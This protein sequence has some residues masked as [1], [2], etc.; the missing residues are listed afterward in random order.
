MLDQIGV[1][2]R[3]EAEKKARPA[4]AGERRGLSPLLAPEALFR[5]WGVCCRKKGV[6]YQGSWGPLGIP[7]AQGQAN[8]EPISGDVAPVRWGCGHGW[9]EAW[10]RVLR[11]LRR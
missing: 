1:Q 5:V 4:G 3:A 9:G 7:Q 2:G 6:T 10:L 11:Q 8:C